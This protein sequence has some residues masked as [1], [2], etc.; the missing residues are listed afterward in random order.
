MAIPEY[1]DERSHKFFARYFVG[2]A[3]GDN[4]GNYGY[5]W[6]TAHPELRPTLTLAAGRQRICGY[7]GSTARPIQDTGREHW[8]VVGHT[9][10]CKGAMDELEHAD[11][12]KALKERHE[13]EMLGLLRAGPK[14][15]EEVARK[16]LKMS[17]VMH[18]GDIPHYSPERLMTLCEQVNRARGYGEI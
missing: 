17:L 15:P 5:D 11:Q 4:G 3:R 16:A 8:P 18:Y 9:C 12:V 13:R 7:C 1:A 6:N 14:P 10:C 2:S